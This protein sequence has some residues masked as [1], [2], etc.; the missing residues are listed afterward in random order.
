M[1]RLA[2]LLLAGMTVIVAPAAAV[3]D[4]PLDEARDVMQRVDFRGRLRVSWQESGRTR[5]EV[6]DVR[7]SRGEVTIKG[8]GHDV[9]HGSPWVV[10]HA[11]GWDVLWPGGLAARPPGMGRKYT[12]I[13]GAGPIVA[14]RTT[15]LVEVREGRGVRERLAL[16]TE[17]GLLVQREQLA[18]DGTV[19]RRLAFETVEIG[20]TPP[21]PPRTADTA[22]P[23]VGPLKVS[24][25]APYRAPRQLA[26]GYERVGVYRQAGAVHV[27]YSDGL[28]GL[29]VFEQAGALDRGDMP[30]GDAVSVRGRK[31]QRYS[32]AGGHVVVWQAGP[33]TWT[34]VGDGPEDQVLAAARSLPEAPGLSVSQRLR[35]QCRRLVEAVSGRL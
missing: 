16:D 33:A 30:E 20:T 12:A 14:G 3:T 9:A 19:T 26:G 1:R 5:S 28:Y 34:V 18:A 2:P 31:G 10:G 17:T 23:D 35:Q 25:P 11:R 8:R 27:L 24:L 13:R 4:G 15:E 21:P 7:G 6:L 29:S 22:E 32:W